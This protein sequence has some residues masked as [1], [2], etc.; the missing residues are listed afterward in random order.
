MSTDSTMSSTS[1]PTAPSSSGDSSGRLYANPYA[2]VSVKSHVPMMLKLQRSNYSK[3]SS[4][5]CVTCGKFGMMQHIDGS[6][7]PPH[8]P[9]DPSWPTWVQ[10]DYCVYS[11]LYS[12]ISDAILDFT[13][14]DNASCGSPSPITSCPTARRRRST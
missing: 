10:A 11:W 2:I 9:A 13:M 12:S 3:W 1:S 4:F 7:P 8:S 6:A 14:G 5:F